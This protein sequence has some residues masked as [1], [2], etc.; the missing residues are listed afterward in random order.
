MRGGSTE[1]YVGDPS[2]LAALSASREI[3]FDPEVLHARCFP[4]PNGPSERMR[5]PKLHTCTGR[6]TCKLHLT[7]YDLR[8]LPTYI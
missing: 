3:G 5:L 4:N 7:P 2:A 8:L 1:T 6:S